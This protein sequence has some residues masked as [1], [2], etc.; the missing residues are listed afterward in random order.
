MPSTSRFSRRI[1]S[2]ANRVLDREFSQEITY[3]RGEKSITIDARPY[4]AGGRGEDGATMLQMGIASWSFPVSA[5]TLSSEP[6]RGD[7]ITTAA[8]DVY[9]VM[10]ADDGRAWSWANGSKTRYRIDTIRK[11]KA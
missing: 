8:G 7:T 2:H 10:T 11:Q 5:F 9:Q 6:T 4:D 3:R 1:A